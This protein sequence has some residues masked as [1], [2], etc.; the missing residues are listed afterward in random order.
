[1]RTCGNLDVSPAEV[2]R[3]L[4]P[5]RPEGD[6]G[7]GAE[8]ALRGATAAEV[9]GIAE[10]KAARGTMTTPSGVIPVHVERAATGWR[11]FTPSVQASL[12]LAWLRD[13]SDGFVEV[14]TVDPRRKLP[15]PIVVEVQGGA[16]GGAP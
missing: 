1:M 4:Q 2:L 11:L 13:L 7:E 15:G 10:G 12:A 6:P 14:D 8:G 16:G 9:E 3:S 5:V